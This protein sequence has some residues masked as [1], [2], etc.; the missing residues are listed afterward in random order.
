MFYKQPEEMDQFLYRQNL[1]KF[2]HEDNENLK[3]PT[4]N[5]EIELVI[6]YLPKMKNT[7]LDGFSIESI[8]KS[9]IFFEEVFCILYSTTR[10]C[11]M[12]NDSILI[13]FLK[14]LRRQMFAI[15]I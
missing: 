8:I 9:I 5:F 7:G 2:N 12:S 14:C 6:K 11:N 4:I 10:Y 13:K 15:L 3:N 1:Q